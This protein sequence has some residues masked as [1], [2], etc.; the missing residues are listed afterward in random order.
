MELNFLAIAVAAV[1]AFILSGVWYGVFG[2]QLAEL[3]P[4]YADSESPSAKD[5]IVELARNLMVALVLAW[6]VDQIGVEDW[7]QA[8]LLGSALWIG[9]AVVLLIGS[10]YHE[11]VPVKLA[12]IHAGDWLLKLVVI[13]IIVGVW[14]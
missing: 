5:V 1:A 6:L 7:V 9:I 2:S 14:Q 12:S 11:K 13:A 3:H 10:V 4:A 8:A